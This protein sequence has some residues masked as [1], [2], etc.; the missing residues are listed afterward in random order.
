M[1][2]LKQ[3]YQ[4]IK[5]Q[6]NSSPL[7]SKQSL[8]LIAVSKTF[9]SSDIRELFSYGQTAFAENYVQE[10]VGKAKELDDLSI[11]WHY[12]GKIQRH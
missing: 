1:S 2:T 6:I 9:P 12:I 4:M 5:E 3:N 11:D 10:F 8:R 7:F